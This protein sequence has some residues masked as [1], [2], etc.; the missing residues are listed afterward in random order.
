MC[1]CVCV[2]VCVC[3]C[4]CL[5]VCACISYTT[6]SGVYYHYWIILWTTHLQIA[7]R[8]IATRQQLESIDTETFW[9]FM[10]KRS[11]RHKA[12]LRN[13]SSHHQRCDALA[14]EWCRQILV[15]LYSERYISTWP[16]HQPIPTHN[17]PRTRTW[18][19]MQVIMLA[20]TSLVGD[21]L[22]Q[23]LFSPS[24]ILISAENEACFWFSADNFQA[25]FLPSQ[26]PPPE[27]VSMT[28]ARTTLDY[29]SNPI[30]R[31]EKGCTHGKSSRGTNSLLHWPLTHG[32][33]LIVCISLYWGNQLRYLH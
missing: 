17:Y 19:I 10:I 33:V 24:W 25:H 15:L 13:H 28:T 20:M 30:Y 1:V 7:N 27:L 32:N 23:I 18:T 6:Q 21:W 11:P 8:N 12:N 26:I 22:K 3:V 16:H 5:C 4:V 9:D 29:T 2:R 14:S 31:L